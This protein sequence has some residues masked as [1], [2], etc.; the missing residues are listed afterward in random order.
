MSDDSGTRRACLWCCFQHFVEPL[1]GTTGDDHLE[2]S[3]ISL[4]LRRRASAAAQ[5][6]V[7]D[8]RGQHG[9]SR[10][11]REQGHLQLAH[12]ESKEREY[13]QKV[14]DKTRDIGRDAPKRDPLERDNRQ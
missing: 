12:H 3:G 8:S 13:R 2:S 10:A 9:E 1:F 4:A 7:D 5:M 6:R 11:D 14:Q